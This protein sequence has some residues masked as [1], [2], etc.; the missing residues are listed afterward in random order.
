MTAEKVNTKLFI[1]S[2][3]K[4]RRTDDIKISDEGIELKG[5]PHPIKF[6]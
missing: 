1:D 5:F 2:M 6:N 4:F 3:R